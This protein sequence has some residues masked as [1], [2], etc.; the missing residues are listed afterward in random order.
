MAAMDGPGVGIRENGVF[1]LTGSPSRGGVCR[2][3]WSG[4]FDGVR[5]VRFTGKYGV[6]IGDGY[7]GPTTTPHPMASPAF[8]IQETTVQIDHSN[9]LVEFYTTKRSVFLGLIRKNPNY[10]EALD[11]QPGYSITYRIDQVK[12]PASYVKP[13]PGGEQAAHTFMTD[14]E[15]I[16]QERRREHGRI[17]AAT[18]I[19]KK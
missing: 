4:V 9:G 13:A 5:W 1:L 7:N 17:L 16:T 11:L 18:T 14:E 2:M 15:R 12:L 10:E 6:A 8:D 3:V 19:Q